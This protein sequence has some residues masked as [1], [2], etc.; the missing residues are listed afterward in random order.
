MKEENAILKNAVIAFKLETGLETEYQLSAQPLRAPDCEIKIT[1]PDGPIVH[2]YGEVTSRVNDAIIGN[3][4]AHAMRP[5]LM[6]IAPYVPSSQGKKL[7]SLEIAFIDTAGNAYLKSHGLYV[8]VTGKRAEITKEKPVGIFRPAGVK[9]L[10]ALLTA[11]GIEN[12][13]YRTISADTGIARTTI[14]ELMNDLERAGY[15]INRPNKRFLTRKAELIKRWTEVYAERFRIKLNPQRFTSTKKT[16]RWWE[17]IN[18]SDYNA[19]W[20]GETGGAELTRHLRPKVATIYAD[21]QLPKLQLKYGLVRDPRGEIEIVKRF[22]R[23]GEVKSTAPPLVVYADLLSTADERNI[24]T[25]KLIYDEYL[26]QI[27]EDNS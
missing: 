22:W 14:G 18:I 3:I 23:F 16:G 21:N 10:L 25:A 13:D 6:L 19:V 2:Y 20:G 4:A 11:P 8:F 24:E 5:D 1:P 17:E 9:L 7:R 12:A 15:L 27:A 26:A